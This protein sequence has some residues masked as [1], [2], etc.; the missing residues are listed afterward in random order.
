MV[1]RMPRAAVNGIHIEYETHGPV[2]GTPMLLIMG[3][4]QQMVAWPR[5]LLDALATHGFLT[6]RYDSRDTGLST[7]FD[8]VKPP[9]M[10]EILEGGRKAA[11]HSAAYTLEDMADDAAGL[12]A[13]LSIERAHVVGVSLGGMVAQLTAARHPARTQTLISVMSTTSESQLPPPSPE[14]GAALLLRPEGFDEASVVAHGIAA[15]RALG[16]PGYPT[17][18]AYWTE[19]IRAAYRRDYSSAGFAR[20][21]LASMASGHR[22]NILPTV[23]APSLVLHGTDDPLLPLAH[24]ERTAELLPNA[25]LETI[26]GMGHDLPP[27]LCPELARRFAAHADAHPLEGL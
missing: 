25:R 1:R 15:R 12:L 21:L 27:S 13:H 4:A 16:S 17:P 18:D 11:L 26:E 3:I 14:A 7:H 2:D 6:I 5:E 23:T 10:P 24:G 19:S 20:H 8:D 9:S 22:A